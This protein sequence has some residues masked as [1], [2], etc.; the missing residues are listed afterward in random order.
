[1]KIFDEVRQ[2]I[3]DEVV[4]LED[5]NEVQVTISVGVCTYLCEN[6][7]DM[8]KAA[9]NKLYEA[10]EGGRNKVCSD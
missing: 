6:L 9:D 7:D 8:I 4:K 10:K 3:A 1:L 2:H 5:N